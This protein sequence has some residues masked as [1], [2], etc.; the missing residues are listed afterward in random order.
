MSNHE[1]Q[2]LTHPSPPNNN[3]H[4]PGTTAQARRDAHLARAVPVSVP[5]F[6]GDAGLAHNGPGDDR[7]GGDCVGRA[8]QN[9]HRAG[10]N[11]GRGVARL[12]CRVDDVG[13]GAAAVG[14]DRGPLRAVLAAPGHQGQCPGIVGIWHCGPLSPDES[15]ATDH[16]SASRVGSFSA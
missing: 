13:G 10:D 3:T 16:R 8:A 4:K 7:A 15:P 9:G 6:C 1:R 5:S 11:G 14:G 2:P 12:H